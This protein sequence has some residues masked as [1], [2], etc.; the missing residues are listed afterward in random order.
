MEQVRGK[1]Q[2]RDKELKIGHKQLGLFASPTTSDPSA[3]FLSLRISYMSRARAAVLNLLR[4]RQ[5][6]PYDEVWSSAMTF[7]LTWESDL[8]GWLR[9][10]KKDRCLEFGGMKD[11]QRIPQLGKDVHL[12][13]KN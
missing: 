3:Y 2:E 11:N 13:W 7:P 9:E 5:R 8:K 10:W 4:T 6:I 1:A 12:L